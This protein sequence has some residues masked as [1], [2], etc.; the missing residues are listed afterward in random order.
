M[1]FQVAILISKIKPR[2]AGCSNDLQKMRG[3][4]QNTRGGIP[5]YFRASSLFKVIFLTI[6]LKFD[7]IS[8][9]VGGMGFIPERLFDD[10]HHKKMHWW[11]WLS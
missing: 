10:D 2:P 3:G 8:L 9:T 5:V 1:F 7:V 11:C 6:T 4:Q